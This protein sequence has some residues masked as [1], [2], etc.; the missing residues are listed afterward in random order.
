[1]SHDMFDICKL[2]WVAINLNKCKF[3]LCT[4]EI[5]FIN[6]TNHNKSL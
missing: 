2:I 5:A 1:M 4:P 6:S 3:Y